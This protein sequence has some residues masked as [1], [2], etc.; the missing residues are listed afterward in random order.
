MQQLQME[1]NNYSVSYDVAYDVSINSNVGSSDNW[2]A[3]QNENGI[4]HKSDM[5]DIYHDKH[6]IKS[7]CHDKYSVLVV[8]F[9]RPI[10]YLDS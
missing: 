6:A 8:C 2:T 10:Q 4:V 1:E 7:E 3:M 5:I 9:L